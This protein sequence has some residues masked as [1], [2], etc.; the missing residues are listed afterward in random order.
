[1]KLYYFIELY[2]IKTYYEYDS[3]YFDSL[4]EHFWFYNLLLEYMVVII[5]VIFHRFNLFY[6]VSHFFFPEL[7]TQIKRIMFHTKWSTLKSKMFCKHYLSPHF[8]IFWPHKQWPNDA[9]RLYLNVLHMIIIKKLYDKSN[10]QKRVERERERENIFVILPAK[11][12]MN[13]VTIG[14]SFYLH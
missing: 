2:I 9:I 8:Y 5:G 13:N 11:L 7:K 1:M 6:M 12:W 4:N 10:Y 14:Y 3:F